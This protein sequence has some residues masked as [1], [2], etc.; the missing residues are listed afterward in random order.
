MLSQYDHILFL[1]TKSCI[2]KILLD[3]CICYVCILLLFHCKKDNYSELLGSS[4]YTSVGSDWRQTL[5]GIGSKLKVTKFVGNFNVRN[6]RSKWCPKYPTE[7]QSITISWRLQ[8]TY[9]NYMYHYKLKAT[10]LVS[11]P[12]SSP[13]SVAKVTTDWHTPTNSDFICSRYQHVDVV[14]ETRDPEKILWTSIHV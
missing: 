8:C 6:S 3:I 11:Y 12:H 4:I 5:T 2:S 9:K 1:Y 13:F 7:N 14:G 10:F